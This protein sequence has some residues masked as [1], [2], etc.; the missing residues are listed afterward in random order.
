MQYGQP[1]SRVCVVY[2]F[3]TSMRSFMPYCWMHTA[4][5]TARSAQHAVLASKSMRIRHR[6]Q[7]LLAT[8]MLRWR[9]RSRK[10]Q[11]LM[12]RLMS[13]H[14]AFLSTSQRPRS[15]ATARRPARLDYTLCT[16]QSWPHPCVRKR[17]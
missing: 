15:H 17:G 10:M 11:R 13:L 8:Q 3:V 12:Y 4:L 1:V 9:E 14:A 2:P 16:N 5:P 6:L 7:P